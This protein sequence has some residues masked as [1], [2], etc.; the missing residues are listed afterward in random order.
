MTCAKLRILHVYC[1]A[2]RR[3]SC[4]SHH[5]WLRRDERSSRLGLAN[6]RA[7][8]PCIREFAGDVPLYVHPGD[9]EAIASHIQTLL[10]SV[11]ERARRGAAGIDA[12]SSLRWEDVAQRTAHTIEQAATGRSA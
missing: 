7:Q 1:D 2:A 12:A 10:A 4:Q 8:D 5:V 3:A 6:R 9:A 11:D